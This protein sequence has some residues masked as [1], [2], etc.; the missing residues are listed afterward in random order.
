MDLLIEESACKWQQRQRQCTGWMLGHTLQI[1]PFRTQTHV[2]RCGEGLAAHSTTAPSPGTALGQSKRPSPRLQAFPRDSCY[3]VSGAHGDGKTLN[4]CLSSNLRAV[5]A[6]ELPV[7]L[8]EAS[9][10]AP[11]CLPHSL[12]GVFQRTAL[13]VNP[14]AGLCSESCPGESDLSRLCLNIYPGCWLWLPWILWGCTQVPAA[15]SIC[16]SPTCWE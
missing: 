1:L 10:P 16:L 12:P 7:V 11:S 13:H 9:P 14:R 3:P 8:A 5:P 6:S 15:E 4:P 2:P